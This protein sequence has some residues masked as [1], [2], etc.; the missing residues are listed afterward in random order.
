MKSIERGIRIVG[1]VVI[2]LFVLLF[3][4]PF[5]GMMLYDA[6]CANP[7]AILEFLRIPGC[8]AFF[9]G[10]ILFWFAL[11]TFYF[12]LPKELRTVYVATKPGGYR[13]EAIAMLVR[14]YRARHGYD[15]LLWILTA[16]GLVTLVIIADVIAAILSR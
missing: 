16:S 15:W 4:I 14:E 10:P 5:V 7:K 11:M 2:G 13:L 6:I 9:L 8:W 1:Y 3:F 12:R